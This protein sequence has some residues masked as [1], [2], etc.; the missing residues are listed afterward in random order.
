[1]IIKD[2]NKKI[3]HLAK[4][5]VLSKVAS[6]LIPTYLMIISVP[7]AL[8]LISYLVCLLSFDN[9][10]DFIY[11]YISVPLYF[12]CPIIVYIKQISTLTKSYPRKDNDKHRVFISVLSISSAA[13]LINILLFPFGAEILSVSINRFHIASYMSDMFVSSPLA[14]LI[15]YFSVFIIYSLIGMMCTSSFFIGDRSKFKNKFTVTCITFL[16]I[17]VLIL[18]LFVITFILATFTD[19]SG[20]ENIQ[21]NNSF[22]NSNILTAFIILDFISIIAYPILYKITLGKMMII[23]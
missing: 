14:M 2:Q 11:N 19:I 16:A 22:F 5:P 7:F 3:R 12:I 15:F 8:N 17:Y 18:I 9:I 20:I 6:Y 21:I 13:V 4:V 10:S 1:M 23:K